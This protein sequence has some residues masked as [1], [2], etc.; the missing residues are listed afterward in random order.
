ML[1]TPNNRLT[2]T[3]RS[4]ADLNA[5]LFDVAFAGQP[6]QCAGDGTCEA[7]QRL[8]RFTQI[9][10]KQE[11]ANQYKYVMDVDGNGWSGRFHRLMASKSA[12]LKSTGEIA[13]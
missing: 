9:K 1:A 3:S 7:V 5:H 10:M 4:L 13:S 11:E 8:Y 6:I 12:V 2:V